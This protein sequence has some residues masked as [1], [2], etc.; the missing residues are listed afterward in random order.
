MEKT[1]LDNYINFDLATTV[2]I[3]VCRLEDDQLLIESFNIGAEAQSGYSREEVIGKNVAMFHTDEDA[4]MLSGFVEYLEKSEVGFNID[5]QIY[6]KTG[7]LTPVS[8][9]AYPIRENGKIIGTVTFSFDITDQIEQKHSLLD[10]NQELTEKLKKEANTRI[11]IENTLLKQKKLADMGEMI[12]AIAHQWR[13]P[14]NSLALLIQDM[15]ESYEFDEMNMEM[16]E[17]FEKEG[18]DLIQHMANTI[19]DFRSFFS[20]TSK[21]KDFAVIDALVEILKLVETQLSGKKINIVLKCHCCDGSFHCEEGI[22]KPPKA[23]ASTIIHGPQGELK[24]MMVNL[25]YNA[26]DAIK[27]IQEKQPDY[28]GQIEIFVIVEKDSLKIEI[29]DNGTGIKKEALERLFEPYFTT[30]G[31]EKGTGLG[32]HMAKLILE[33]HFK[34]S[35][36]ARNN[37][38]GCTFTITLNNLGEKKQ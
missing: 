25:V 24:Q 3:I 31:D 11:V 1:L 27:E 8:I 12:S 28:I 33:K 38:V 18:L 36:I 9:H 4:S 7:K 21:S 34:G 15:K 30:K 13:Q 35:I 5:T 16:M 10:L 19:D 29:T 17:G 20:P 14:L 22:R 26:A 6:H 23:C 32:L 2:A 37:D